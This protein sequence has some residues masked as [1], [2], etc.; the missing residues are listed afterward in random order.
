M[1]NIISVKKNTHEEIKYV[2]L[3]RDPFLFPKVKVLKKKSVQPVKQIP[4]V[5]L[6]NYRISGIIVNEKSKLLIFEDNTN[7]TTVF[8]H[9]GE[10]YKDIKIKKIDEEKVVLI[11][12][13]KRKEI[14]MSKQ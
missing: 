12:Q 10:T 6:L 7:K 5:P 13:G 1:K 3:E 4:K 11:E 9:E 8:L 14:I 2:K